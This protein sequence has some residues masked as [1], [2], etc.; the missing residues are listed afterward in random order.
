M[1]RARDPPKSHDALFW[2]SEAPGGLIQS[3]CSLAQ[4]SIQMESAFVVYADGS[5]IEVDTHS[6]AVLRQVQ[7]LQGAFHLSA[8][9]VA[10]WPTSTSSAA[11][12][13]SSSTA[14]IV[15]NKNSSKAHFWSCFDVRWGVE[16]PS[17][18]KRP[19]GGVFRNS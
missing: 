2:G 17:E 13:I 9:Q 11:S 12:S 10:T 14:I 7:S 19:I 6:G 8:A 4:P 15:Q 16:T 5:I 3:H 18:M 1:G